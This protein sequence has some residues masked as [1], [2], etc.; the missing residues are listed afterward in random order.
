[1]IFFTVKPL[2]TK[3]DKEGMA[4]AFAA[5]GASQAVGSVA[6]AG[7]SIGAAFINKQVAEEQLKA[8]AV[9]QAAQIASN[10]VINSDNLAERKLEFTGRID[11]EKSKQTNSFYLLKRGEDRQDKIIDALLSTDPT[12]VKISGA[13][14]GSEYVAS[15]Q[16]QV[17]QAGG[18]ISHQLTLKQQGEGAEAVQAANRDY[19]LASV[20]K[21]LRSGGK[22][23][24][25]IERGGK[26]YV[27]GDPRQTILN[28]EQA[29]PTYLGGD[30]VRRKKRN[31]GLLTNQNPTLQALYSDRIRPHGLT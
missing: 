4:A 22:S 24:V 11:L 21:T 18:T 27:K 31:A 26:F 30:G 5:L 12:N 3:V 17:P 7:A 19:A 2:F 9:A 15:V 8:N 1:M 10:Q 6:S 29:A 13:L 28:Q 25:V 20:A 16:S 23:N 14:S